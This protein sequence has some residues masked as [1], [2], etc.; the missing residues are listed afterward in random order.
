MAKKCYFLSRYVYA[1]YLWLEGGPEIYQLLS[2]AAAYVYLLVLQFD[3]LHT[4]GSSHGPT[5][6][7]RRAYEKD[8][9]VHMMDEAFVLWK[10]I[11]E[12]AGIKIYQ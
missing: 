12:K 4:R 7:T 2:T 6:I 3:A 5:R 8:F 9:Y 10:Q 1:D 11:E